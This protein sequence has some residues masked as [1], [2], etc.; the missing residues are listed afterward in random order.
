[1]KVIIIYNKDLDKVISKFGR[2][3]EE[4]YDENAVKKINEILLNHDYDVMVIDGNLDMFE[5]LRKISTE[6]DEI[7]FVFNLAYGIQ[8]ESRYTHI[9][10]ILEMLGLP[11]LGSGPFGHTLALDKIIIK[12]LMKEYNIPTPLFTVYNLPDDLDKK[13]DID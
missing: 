1:M 13:H 7:P 2:Q 11:Y 4:L 5:K 12:T 3:N 8:G 6:K 10:S 9:P